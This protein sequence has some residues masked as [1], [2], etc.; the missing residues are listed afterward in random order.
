MTDKIKGYLIRALF[1][2]CLVA[3][4][5]V[6]L[7]RGWLSLDENLYLLLS[8]VIGGFSCILFMI[9]FSITKI[10]Y[11]FG[12]RKIFM[13]LL[14][15]PG[16]IIAINN[17]PF[18]SYFA[19]DC[20]IEQGIGNILFYALICLSVGFFEEMAF[21]GCVFM[22][23]LKKRTE[24]KLRI[25]LAIVWSSAVFGVIHL[26][27]IFFGSSPVAVLLQ[28]GYSTL[29]GALCSVVLL[30]TGNIWLCVFLHSLYNFCGGIIS[31]YGSGIQWTGGE[32]AFTAI[33]SVIVA[34]YFVVL[35]WRMPVSL[36]KDLF[37]QNK[38]DQ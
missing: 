20:R 13:L 28:I 12:N 33:I 36:A 27:N 24:S 17:F 15:L 10:F 35:F 14:A 23:F 8:R 26:V 1:A 21:R 18:V 4:L 16:F 25:F 29:I 22:L 38:D 3:L 5:L 32:I 31:G 11:P 37:P 6:E 9:E 34:V 2:V 30:L 19:G 7:L